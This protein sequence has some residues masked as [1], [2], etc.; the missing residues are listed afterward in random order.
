MEK[1]NDCFNNNYCL[2][3]LCIDLWT[4]GSQSI[5][6]S[7][8]SEKMQEIAGAIQEGAAAYLNRQYTT[9]TIVGSNC[10]Y[11]VIFNFRAVCI[12]WFS[13]WSCFIW[14]SW[15]HRYECFR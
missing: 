1:I 5:L 11:N 3:S 9:I 7:A 12:N 8:G 14:Y 13:H 6:S 2:R 15:L 10:C 4:L